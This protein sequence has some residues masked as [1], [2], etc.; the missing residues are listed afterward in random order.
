MDAKITAAMELLNAAAKEKK[1]DMG[2]L[3]SEKYGYLKDTLMDTPKDFV[4][5]NPW[6]AA[7]GL[8]LSVLTAGI[9]FFL[10]QNQKK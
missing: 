10:Y 2:K 4:K 8:A 7:G 1:E 5:E 3:I 9:I 6:W